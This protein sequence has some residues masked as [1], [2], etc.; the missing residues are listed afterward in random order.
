MIV[1]GPNDNR[2]NDRHSASS[3][4]DRKFGGRRKVTNNTEKAEDYTKPSTE[5]RANM[6]GEADEKI[7]NPVGETTKDLDDLN[8]PNARKREASRR[9][10]T[11]TRG[12]TTIEYLPGNAVGDP[13]IPVYGGNVYRRPGD[14]D[15]KEYSMTAGLI[16]NEWTTISGIIPGTTTSGLIAV[17][18]VGGS[19]VGNQPPPDHRED[20]ATE[21]D[22]DKKHGDRNPWRIGEDYDEPVDK[23][24]G[25]PTPR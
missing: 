1:L 8:D 17:P 9:A 14:S 15:D 19:T 16:V 22:P 4:K 13:A 6:D 25:E 18:V 23:N 7:V 10:E 12:S 2:V 3:P 11:S 20:D 21:P 5:R 24:I